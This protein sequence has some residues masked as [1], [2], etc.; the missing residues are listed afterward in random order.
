MAAPILAVL[1]SAV[2]VPVFVFRAEDLRAA[3]PFYSAAERFWARVSVAVLSL[4]VALG[5]V[6][7][8]LVAPLSPL[9]A[10]CAVAVTGVGLGLWLCA[11]RQIM[12]LCVRRLPAEAPPVLRRDGAFRLVRNPCYL[13]Y[14]LIAAG[15]LI[16][17]ASPVL[18]ATWAAG[19][20][21]L[22][23]R[24]AQEE[25]RLHAQLGAAYA[26]YCSKAKRLIPFAW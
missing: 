18:V 3:L 21:A 10:A 2:W 25:H 19:F 15:P 23:K 20:V 24:A 22:A 1:F 16:V 4:H 17:T 9:R 12:P 6:L 13:A 8:S 5:T 26:D 11:R 14:L 7:V